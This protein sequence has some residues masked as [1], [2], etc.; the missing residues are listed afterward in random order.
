MTL[1]KVVQRIERLP[2]E[3]S[4]RVAAAIFPKRA[5]PTLTVLTW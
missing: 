5:T 2:P 3:D 1:L 4:R